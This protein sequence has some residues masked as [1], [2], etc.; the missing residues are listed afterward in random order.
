MKTIISALALVLAVPAAAQTTAPVAPSHSE[1]AQHG[2]MNHAQHQG[3]QGMDHS[4]HQGMDHSQHQGT[5]CKG[6]DHQACCEKAKADGKAMPCC[7]DGS[8]KPGQAPAAGHEGHAGHE[9]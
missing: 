8:G 4:Q 9:H 5:C 1:P 6:E 3:H 2:G 7:Q